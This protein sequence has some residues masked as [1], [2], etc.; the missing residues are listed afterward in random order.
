MFE[1]D[2]QIDGSLRH[3]LRHLAGADDA[4]IERVWAR[5][6]ARPLGHRLD[7]ALDASDGETAIPLRLD[8]EVR[9]L[10][11]CLRFT[12]HDHHGYF[13]LQGAM[14]AHAPLQHADA[15]V[16]QDRLW[17]AGDQRVARGHIDGES[18]VPGFDKDRTGP[19]LDLLARQG[20]PDGRLIM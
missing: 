10:A 16:Q 19:V 18:L 7:E 8:V 14:D 6:R 11:Q 1:R 9:V 15:G 5:H 12:R 13:V 4:L 2:V 17:P 3:A 20:L